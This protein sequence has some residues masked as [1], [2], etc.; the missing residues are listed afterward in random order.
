MAEDSKD[1]ASLQRYQRF[2]DHITDE[3]IAIEFEDTG[4]VTPDDGKKIY[5]M[6]VGLHGGDIQIGA[7]EIKDK[8]SDIRASVDADGLFVNVKKLPAVVGYLPPPFDQYK[9][10]RYIVG[11]D[12]GY[13]DS[14]TSGV[15]PRVLDVNSDLG[16]NAHEGNFINDGPGDIYLEISDNG[17]NY[18]SSHK[19]KSLESY[20]LTAYDINK[21]RLTWISNM[22]YRA[23]VL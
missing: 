11:R 17:T 18:G 23:V 15:S 8:D 20:D 13:E 16:R 21:I 9:F 5:R 1:T 10:I 19:V 4:E 22:A 2:L 14:F 7:V 3:V 12:K 6:K